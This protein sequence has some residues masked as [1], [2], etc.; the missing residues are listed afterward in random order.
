[1]GKETIR[2]IWEHS[3]KSNIN[4]VGTCREQVNC[5]HKFFSVER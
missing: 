4:I 5:R 2:D 3:E 1:M